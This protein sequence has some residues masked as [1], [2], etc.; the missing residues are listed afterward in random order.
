M[1]KRRTALEGAR[2]KGMQAAIA[3]ETA[4]T[5][6]YSDLRKHDGKLTW[7]RAFRTAWH[8]GFESATKNREQALIT[9][10]Y[11]RPRTNL[12]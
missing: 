1:V 7:S 12:E 4:D 2:L 11:S 5:C 10:M 3:G 9:L 6:P 8:D